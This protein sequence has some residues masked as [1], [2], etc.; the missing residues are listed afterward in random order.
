MYTGKKNVPGPLLG[1]TLVYLEKTYCS[2]P[3]KRFPSP[4]RNVRLRACPR[5]NAVDTNSS[6]FE[7]LGSGRRPDPDGNGALTSRMRKRCTPCKN[8]YSNE[9][10]VPFDISSS[11]PA[12]ACTR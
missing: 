4:P 1:A 5:R 7:K 11:T 3:L 9:S 8:E 6:T 12:L 2:K 10:Q